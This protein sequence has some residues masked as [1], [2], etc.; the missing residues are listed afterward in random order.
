M[1][2]DNRV[3]NKQTMINVNKMRDEEANFDPVAR[4][5]VERAVR[6]VKRI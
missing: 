4:N 1:R 5:E 6:G 2:T 3:G